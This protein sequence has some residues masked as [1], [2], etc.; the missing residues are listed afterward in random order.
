MNINILRLFFS[1][2]P[3]QRV[4]RPT[5]PRKTAKIIPV[6]ADHVSKACA[7][8]GSTVACASSSTFDT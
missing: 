1:L 8:S 6:A 2:P 5:I 4:I 7:F 3:K